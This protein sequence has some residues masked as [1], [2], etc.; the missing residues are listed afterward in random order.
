MTDEESQKQ[1]ELVETAYRAGM[2][3]VLEKYNLLTKT[4]AELEE[5]ELKLGEQ[6]E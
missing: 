4:Q 2:L 3:Y 6:D 5:L 1:K